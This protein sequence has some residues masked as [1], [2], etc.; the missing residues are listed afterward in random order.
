MA[1]N[2]LFICSKFIMLKGDLL[3][4]GLID[5]CQF[6]K[7]SERFTSSNNTRLVL[8]QSNK[9][10]LQF[11]LVNSCTFCVTNRSR[12]KS[13]TY[14]LKTECQL[15]NVILCVLSLAYTYLLWQYEKISS[16]VD[17]DWRFLIFFLLFGVECSILYPVAVTW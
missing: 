2:L 9:K 13:L 7:Y 11:I 4:S 1:Y 6:C 16:S 17:L 8:H 14:L 10:H 15:R 3:H 12:P 5:K